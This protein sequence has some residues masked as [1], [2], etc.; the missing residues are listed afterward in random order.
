MSMVSPHYGCKHI[1]YSTIISITETSTDRCT[2]ITQTHIIQGST[3]SVNTKKFEITVYISFYIAVWRKKI[4]QTS[5]AIARVHILAAVPC[6]P[7][8][9]KGKS[10][11]GE[12]EITCLIPGQ[13]FITDDQSSL[14]LASAQKPTQINTFLAIICQARELFSRFS[15]LPSICRTS[16]GFKRRFS[17]ALISLRLFNHL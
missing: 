15:T 5:K 11:L 9:S 17:K 7:P 1:L 4:C 10:Q 3:V 2:H 16:R 14:F 12:M 6:M 8:H 13:V